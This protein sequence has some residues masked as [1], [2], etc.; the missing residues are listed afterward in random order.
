MHSLFSFI[1]LQFYIK[2]PLADITS[3]SIFSIVA[4]LVQYSILNIL[5][6]E[7]DI[8]TNSYYKNIAIG[9]FWQLIVRNVFNGN[10]ADVDDVKGLS[11]QYE[12][13]EVILLNGN[14]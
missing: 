7:F 13:R 9:F 8:F 6:E 1:C 10:I 2:Y 3:N 11:L 12:N 14:C 5:S 4:V